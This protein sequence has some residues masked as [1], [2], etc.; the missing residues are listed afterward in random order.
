MGFLFYFQE[1]N[2]GLL[3]LLFSGF[4]AIVSVAMWLDYF[5]CIDVFEKEK[6]HH[7]VLPLIIGGCA[8]YLS[9]YV[10]HTFD[11]FG[12]SGNGG[13]FNDIVYSVIGIGLNEELSKLLAFFIVVFLLRKQVNEPIDVLIYAGVTAL[14]F[15]LVEN[16]YYFN[17]HGVKIITSRTFY[18]ALE[19]IINTTIIVYGIYRRKLF[20]K[21]NSLLNTIVALS[22]AVASHGLFDFFLL[23]SIAGYFTAIL[24]A[25]IYLIGINFW[26]QMLNNA[27]NYSKFFDYDKIHYST[28]IVSRLLIWY[29]LTLVIAFVNNALMVDMK[30]S[31]ITFFYSMVSD[32]FVFFI[33]IL[34]VSRFKILKLKYFTVKPQFPFYVTRNNDEDF[35]FPFL[36]LPIKV[37]GENYLEYLLT[38]Y[39]N[40][41]VRL[42]PV[43][44]KKSFLKHPVEAMIT[45]KFLLFDDVIVY[46]VA[47]QGITAKHNSLFLLK[48]KTS[49]KVFVDDEYPIEGLY[50]V[51]L[52]HDLEELHGIDFK[53]LEFI[54]WIYLV[55]EKSK[56]KF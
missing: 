31:I 3:F 36:N 22:V 45:D 14:G 34:R 9:L 49:G 5:R 42:Y 40:R 1:M 50:E 25:I 21:G 47:V 13:F 17:N 37:R 26:I 48:P 33:V 12:F 52:Q 24:S 54:E 4:A 28:S 39:L 56:I 7:L 46:A 11:H 8:P 16:Y 27:N 6:I 51:E 38:R 32:G 55:P 35:V 10:Y 53:K 29:A 20:G 19:H 15:S 23:D 2:N 43:N 30:F 41:P 44:T 18:S